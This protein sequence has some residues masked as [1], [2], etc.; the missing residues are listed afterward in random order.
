MDFKSVRK[1]DLPEGIDSLEEVYFEWWLEDLMAMG[2]VKFFSRSHTFKITE[3]VKISTLKHKPTKKDPKRLLEQESILL[4]GWTYTADYDILWED[5]AYGV[6]IKD[7]DIPY[8]TDKDYLLISSLTDEGYLSTVDVKP[9]G[10][11]AGVTSSS[12]TFPH[13]QKI[14]FDRYRIYVNKVCPTG[15][16]SLFHKTFTPERYFFQDVNRKNRRISLWPPITLTQ[17]LN[18]K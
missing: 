1:S 7:I 15:K 13:N 14:M 6:F 9:I 3:P 17:F 5:K 2:F 18:K 12:I 10:F 16:K 8:K 11:K 4:R